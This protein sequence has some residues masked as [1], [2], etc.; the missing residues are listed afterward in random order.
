[1]NQS[2]SQDLQKLLTTFDV[3]ALGEGDINA[4]ANLL[5]AMA[6]SLANFAP[7]DDSVCY[8]DGT[9]VRLGASLLVSG[10][11]SSS[12]IME[13]V[14]TGA[15][16]RQSNLAAHLRRYSESIV[17][18]ASKPGASA[19]PTGRPASSSQYFANIFGDLGPLLGTRKEAWWPI[20]E[21][22]P[23]E[24][25]NDFLNRPKF[26]VSAARPKDLES[27]LEGLRPGR[28]LIHLG[29]NQCS[30]LAE[31]SDPGAALIEGR[32]PIGNGGET[33]RGN[34]LLTDPLQLLNEAAK[35]PDPRTSWLGHFLWL[36]DGAA[37][38][39]A[40]VDPTAAG[41]PN[42]SVTLSRFR[43]ALTGVLI[44]RFYL[45]GNM[46]QKLRLDTR[47]DAQRWTSFLKEMEPLM[48]GITSTARNLPNSLVFGLGE[49]AK[50]DQ[51]LHFTMEEVMSLCRFLVRRAVN[52]RVAIIHEAEVAR[53]QALANRIYLKIE[54]GCNDR[55][56][57]CKN[58][59]I[60]AADFDGCV[61]W[62]EKEGIVKRS[63]AKGSHWDM[64]KGAKL[65]FRHCRRPLLEINRLEA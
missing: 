32:Y 19:A 30:D 26:L 38:P 3:N 63:E 23:M 2:E 22:R 59:G 42:G 29:I 41:H 21:R 20:L 25:F 39:D 46:P 11:L 8:E 15:A 61:G 36:V 65:D 58:T 49:M 4:G 16:Q 52:A 62:L 47:A 10:V 57:I 45:G 9:P 31:F 13:E 54:Q 17:E 5:T 6:I 12:I 51:A 48:P 64:V 50:I 18:Q 44:N 1:M 35:D 53:L 24:R 28:P 34:F 40:P 37:G 27:Q 33:I 14:V 60:N 55:R 7:T 43:R 56:L